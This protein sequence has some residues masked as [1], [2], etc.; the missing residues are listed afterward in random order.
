M[1][2]G[3]YPST[4]H[5][6]GCRSP[7][8]WRQ[9]PGRLR[10]PQ[11]DRDA[12]SASWRVSVAKIGSKQGTMAPGRSLVAKASARAASALVFAESDE[13]VADDEDVPASAAA[14]HPVL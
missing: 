14:A 2:I 7:A 8:A 13:V 12:I 11:G 5:A 1:G 10:Q 4:R 3:P 6:C 9:P